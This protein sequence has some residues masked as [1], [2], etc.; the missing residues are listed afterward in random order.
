MRDGGWF[1]G[2]DVPPPQLRHLPAAAICV[3]EQMY[4]DVVA[5]F[6]ES[7]FWSPNTYYANHR[8][9]RAYSLEKAK[10]D[11]YVHMPVLFIGAKWDAISDITVS[12]IADTQKEYCSNLKEIALNAGHWVALE[13]AC[14]VNAAIVQWIV[15]RCGHMW[16]SW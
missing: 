2:A 10:N 14:E 12:R 15:E 13:K 5:A 7:R 3:D 11:G 16:P 6:E 4:S 9:N 1:G 8:R